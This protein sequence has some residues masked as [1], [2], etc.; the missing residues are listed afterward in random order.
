MDP[1][2]TLRDMI[3]A[4]HD[5]DRFALVERAEDLANWIAHGGFVPDVAKTLT[6]WID[7]NPVTKQ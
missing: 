3:D 6:T 2:A 5:N 7:N 4:I 1:N